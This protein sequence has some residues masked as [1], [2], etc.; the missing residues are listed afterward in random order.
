MQNLDLP[1]S[2]AFRNLF[3]LMSKDHK[4]L[5]TDE[6]RRFLGGEDVSRSEVAQLLKIPRTTAYETE[7]RLPRDFVM[8]KLLP[9]AMA[10][11]LAFDLFRDKERAR[12]WMITPNSFFFAKS[13]L[14][15]CLVGDGQ[16]VLE[17]LHE[18][19]GHRVEEKKVLP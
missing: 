8:A 4:K 2:G 12:M 13:P 16:A 3:G 18:R 9:F 19:L 5:R 1:D 14:D 17:F 11:D 10:S 6:F 7:L 15:V